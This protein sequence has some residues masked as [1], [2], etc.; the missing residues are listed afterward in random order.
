[1]IVEVWLAMFVGTFKSGWEAYLTNQI[2][3]KNLINGSTESNYRL[4]EL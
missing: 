4:I 2:A 3:W 1:M